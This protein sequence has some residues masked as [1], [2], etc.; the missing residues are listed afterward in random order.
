MNYSLSLEDLE[1]IIFQMK[2]SICKISKKKNETFTGFFCKIPYESIIMS[3]LI[4]NGHI[5][6]E[7]DKNNEF[8]IDIS[9]NNEKEFRK[10]K[11]DKNRIIFNDKKKLDITIIEIKPEDKID[12]Y[13]EIDD[14]INDKNYEINY[15]NSLIYILH[16]PKED[17]IKVSYNSIYDLIG[18][19]IFINQ[20]FDEGSSGSPILSLNTFKVI[21]INK[22]NSY[23][24]YN[25]ATLIKYA[26]K[27]FNKKEIDLNEL[28]IKY[29][30]KNY[31]FQIKLFDKYFVN[32]NINN[33]KL[34]IGGK[35]KDIKDYLSYSYKDLKNENILEIKLIEIR[36]INSMC[37]MFNECRNLISLQDFG[38]WDMSNVIDVSNMFYNCTSLNY[39]SDISKWNTEKITNIGYMFYGCKSLK[40]LPDI[41]KWNIEKVEDISNMFNGCSSLI[42]LPDLSKW[43]LNNVCDINNIFNKCSLLSFLP[44]ISKWNTKKITDMS[45]IFYECTKIKTLPDI[46]KW[47]MDNVTTINKMFYGCSSLISLPDISLFNISKVTDL[48]G[49]FY[50]CSSLEYLPDISKWKT[51]NVTDMTDMF[52]GCKSLKFLPDISKW[53]TNNVTNIANIFYGCKSLSRLPDISKWNTNN[54]SDISNLF[55]GCSSLAYLPN[56]SKW[57][58]ENVYFMSTMFCQCE[59]LAFLPNISDWNVKNVNEDKDKKNKFNNCINLIK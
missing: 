22:A 31:E 54:F 19:N 56:I 7:E 59:S 13:L 48:S 8:I 18:N 28:T 55:Y 42:S 14:N 12:N 24:S 30:V 38:E 41:S 2:N 52:Y 26:I 37:Q 1:I 16:Y 34:L 32:N 44:D 45:N 43:A 10:L 21:G 4:T 23:Y 46:S 3:V 17:K 51:N 39:V 20:K 35:I 50:N 11:I 36:K 47:R 57:N 5:L 58:T 15:K 6:N 33:C 9:M 27:K 40:T 53:N 25:L 29:E 49:I